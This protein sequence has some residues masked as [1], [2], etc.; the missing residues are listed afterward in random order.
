MS[1]HFGKTIKCNDPDCNQMFAAKIDMQ[2][3]FKDS[4]GD[5]NIYKCYC[6]HIET[7]RRS[8]IHHIEQTH[9]LRD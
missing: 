3:H 4:H 1:K 9:V 7:E 2:S 5:S 6:G 8:L